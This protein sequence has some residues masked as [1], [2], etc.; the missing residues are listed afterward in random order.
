MDGT[1]ESWIDQIKEIQW[2]LAHFQAIM[3]NS[4]LNEEWKTK[5]ML[6]TV[7]SNVPY[8]LFFCLRWQDDQFVYFLVAVSFST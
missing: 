8:R 1:V 6:N 5:E 7:I 4:Y 3:L 2:N